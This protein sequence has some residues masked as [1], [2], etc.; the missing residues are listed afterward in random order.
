M[1]LISI[2][3]PVF[4]AETTI[5]ETIHSVLAQTLIDFELLIINDGSTD[6]TLDIISTIDDPRINIFTFPNSGV[7]KSRN[8]GLEK[9]SGE[10]ISFIDADDL[11]TPN[12]LERQWHALQANSNAS[13]AYSWTNYINASGKFVREGWHSQADGDVY[14]ELAKNC[15][16]ENGSN[17]LFR[18]L[19]LS[20][21]DG[22]D[23][24]LLMCEDWDFYLRL[25]EKFQF[26]C[27]PEPQILYRIS[28]QSRSNN[29]LQMER[30][31]LEV[32][33]R[34]FARSPK[35]LQT[36][37]TQSIRNYYHYLIY[38]A[39]GDAKSQKQSWVALQILVRGIFTS[40]GLFWTIPKSKILQ[41]MQ[42]LVCH[43]G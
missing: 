41:V 42:V 31:G 9:A 16:I 7:V 37:R 11:W 27:V 34:T 36:V 20:E 6:A 40:P 24:S 15:F 14:A 3:L 32:L 22:F 25:A 1:P 30:D 19:I 10:L 28:P 2:I 29:L 13:V 35:R 4:N 21:I 33:R 38:R 5:A 23:D 43:P 17:I 8:R 26:V 39:L 12:K 18:R